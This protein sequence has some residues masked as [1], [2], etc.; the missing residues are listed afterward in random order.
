MSKALPKVDRVRIRLRSSDHALPE[1]VLFVALACLLLNALDCYGASLTSAKARKCCASGHCSPANL[2]SCCRTSPTGA[3]QAFEPHSK[4]SVQKPVHTIDG[5]YI[6]PGQRHSNPAI[7]CDHGLIQTTI[8]RLDSLWLTLYHS[9]SS[10]LDRSFPINQSAHLWGGNP[11]ADT[12]SIVSCRLKG[13]FGPAVFSLFRREQL[14]EPRK[15]R[16]VLCFKE[17]L[18][19]LHCSLRQSPVLLGEL[20]FAQSPPSIQW[21]S[22]AQFHQLLK[23]EILGALLI[24]N[25]GIEFQSPK[26]SQRWPYGEI[27][28]FELSGARELSHYRLRESPLA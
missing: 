25:N 10:L 24:D 6:D 23:K 13:G 8:L 27:K 12:I 14:S 22:P 9:A 7:H 1:V 5:L 17:N 16:G 4:V 11:P 20:A 28:T 26:F 2:D 18:F 19:Y 15:N 21:Q 3:N